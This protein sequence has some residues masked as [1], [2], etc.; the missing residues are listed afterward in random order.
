MPEQ[1]HFAF[2]A[3]SLWLAAAWRGRF[4]D[5]QGTW[6]IRFAP[7][8]D[9]LGED[10]ISIQSESLFASPDLPS[11]FIGYR[12]DSQGIPT[13]SY[14][15]GDL[16]VEDRI[17]ALAS[18]ESSSRPGLKRNL[19]LRLASREPESEAKHVIPAAIQLLSGKRL[20]R[21][22]EQSVQNED[23]LLVTLC[24]TA[25]GKSHGLD[26]DVV[27]AWSLP[28]HV[29]SGGPPEAVGGLR[30]GRT[31]S[32]DAGAAESLELELTYQW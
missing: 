18:T 16:I 20:T 15:V 32:G 30:L 24:E 19:R 9:P 2:D 10:E 8:A 29:V 12:L 6:F 21:L 14:R 1:V 13:F 5:A 17:T 27:S 7:P 22:D 11:R 4:V 26:V 28:L 31:V 25:D 3:Q 23:G